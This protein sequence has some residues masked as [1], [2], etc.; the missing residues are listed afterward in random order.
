MYPRQKW[1]FRLCL[2]ENNN[3]V[4][5]TAVTLSVIMNEEMPDRNQGRTAREYYVNPFI[6]F[7]SF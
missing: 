2:Q 1:V 6:R 3:S 7:S 4:V 5:N